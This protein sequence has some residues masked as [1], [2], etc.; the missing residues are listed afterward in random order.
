[1]S[2]CNQQRE[3]VELY[4][5]QSQR[6]QEAI[7]EG[8]FKRIADAAAKNDKTFNDAIDTIGDGEIADG[9]R[10]IAKQEV[11]YYVDGRFFD[12]KNQSSEL[13]IADLHVHLG[14]VKRLFGDTGI[15]AGLL[16][17]CLVFNGICAFLIIFAQI[18]PTAWSNALIPRIATAMFVVAMPWTIAAG[19][20]LSGPNSILVTLIYTA[21]ICIAGLL[22]FFTLL[23]VTV[24]VTCVSSSALEN[25]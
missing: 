7:E 1:M 20:L 25:A 16:K 12:E 11:F 24:A 18:V 8:H 23:W 21:I 4:L 22:Y 15:A 13:F 5:A 10:E 17:G 9:V 14:I 6:Q 3:A 2:V 19:L